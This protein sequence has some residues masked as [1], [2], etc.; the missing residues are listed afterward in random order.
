M[1]NEENLKKAAEE[2]ARMY[3]ELMAKYAHLTSH[4]NEQLER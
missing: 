4:A 1:Q 2:G 3:G